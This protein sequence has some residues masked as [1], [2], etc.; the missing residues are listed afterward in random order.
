MF[1][2]WAHS[3]EYDSLYL[4]RIL[5]PVYVRLEM[6][7]ARL[8]MI[9][10][11]KVKGFLNGRRRRVLKVAASDS[12]NARDNNNQPLP[13][14]RWFNAEQCKDYAEGRGATSSSKKRSVDGNLVHQETCNAP[15][16]VL[17]T[18]KRIKTRHT[19]HDSDEDSTSVTDRKSD[20]Q[21]GRSYLYLHDMSDSASQPSVDVPLPSTLESQNAHSS[22]LEFNNTDSADMRTVMSRLLQAERARSDEDHQWEDNSRGKSKYTMVAEYFSQTIQRSG[23]T[24]M[25]AK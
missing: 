6:L 10:F 12:E 9:V 18:P 15:G 25:V 19:A 11:P 24:F 3:N 17:G 16:L 14:P 20:C 13:N 23:L 4:N 21:D 22:T 8:A 1:S 5:R 2:L 7:F